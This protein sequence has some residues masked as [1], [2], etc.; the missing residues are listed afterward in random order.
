MRNLDQNLAML[1]Y[2]HFLRDLRT[3]NHQAIN[4]KR[5]NRKKQKSINN[6]NRRRY[7]ASTHQRQRTNCHPHKNNLKRRWPP[8]L[9][10]RSCHW[11]HNFR[12]PRNPPLRNPKNPRQKD[13]RPKLSS[14]YGRSMNFKKWSSIRALRVTVQKSSFL[15]VYRV[16]EVGTTS[17]TPVIVVVD[18]SLTWSSN[19]PSS[20]NSQTISSN[21]ELSLNREIH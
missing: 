21:S 4:H 18:G 3:N 17:S 14:Y 12:T 9:S 6:S 2:H 16:T 10:I 13:Y 8:F 19:L 5:E 1:P 11:P 7:P 15:R 20:S